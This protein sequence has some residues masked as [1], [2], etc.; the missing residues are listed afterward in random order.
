M[1]QRNF[2]NQKAL[3]DYAEQNGLVYVWE[4]AKRQRLRSSV[5]LTNVVPDET[6]ALRGVEH[7]TFVCSECHVTEHRVVFI[8][9]G[10]ETD[11]PPMPM[12]AARHLK[13]AS[14]EQDEHVVAPGFLSRV[15][16]LVRRQQ[17]RA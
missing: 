2:E 5:I 8:K 16:A 11:S 13:R 9:D 15:L 14:T 10:R 7:H 1:P 6:V 4:F 17:V 3:I 12:Q